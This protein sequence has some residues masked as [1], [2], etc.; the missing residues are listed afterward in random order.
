ML[1]HAKGQVLQA[2][3]DHL[4]LRALARLLAQVRKAPGVEHERVV[5]VRAALV[6]RGHGRRDVVPLRDEGAIRER[7]VL[8]G[9]ARE[10]H[11]G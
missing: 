7:V 8:D 10:V 9:L 3:V 4:M 6:R 11:C 5:V 1:A 2:R